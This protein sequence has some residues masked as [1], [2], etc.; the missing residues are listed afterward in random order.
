[1]KIRKKLLASILLVAIVPLII[2]TLSY[3]LFLKRIIINQVV[4]HLE[5]VATIQ[6]QRVNDIIDRNLERMDL[7]SS[8]TQLR[9]S[10]G[11]YLRK[12]NSED[13][14]KMNK[15]LHDARASISDFRHISVISAEGEV[16]ASTDGK[17]IGKNYA[18][19]KYF[20][21]GLKR[22]TFDNF[23]LDINGN[24]RVR[25]SGPIFLDHDFLGVVVIDSKMD[26]IN[27]LT[28]DYT[29]LGESGE[30]I[31]ARR[32]GNGNALILHPLRFDS[33]ATLT[34]TIPT[35]ADKRPIT[36]ALRKKERSMIDAVGYRGVPVIT[37]TRYIERAD[38]GLAVEIDRDEAL[39]PVSRLLL[40]V[41]INIVVYLIIVIV[42]A[43]F[44]SKALIKPI[45]RLTQA[46]KKISENG[47][48][49]ESVEIKNKD[50][51]GILYRAFNEMTQKLFQSQEN[52][53]LQI[54]RMP[55]G[56]LMYDGDLQIHTWNPA[57]EKIF[58]FTAEEAMRKN[59][60]ELIVPKEARN[61][62]DS[63]THRLFE[64]DMDAH[65][66][67]E[68]L[69][70]DGRKILCD[71]TNTPL[72]DS[73]GKVVGILAMVRDI[74][75]KNTLEK[76][77]QQAQKLEAVGRLT[78]GIAHDFN[79]VLSAIIGY[80]D[81]I[82]MKTDKED[83]NRQHLQEIKKAGERA[84]A[85]T[86]QLLA[87]S[88]KQVLKPEVLDPNNVIKELEKMIRRIIGEDIIFMANLKPDVDRI[89]ADPAQMEQIIMNLAINA[90]D[91]MPTGG[92]LTIETAN[93]FLDEGYA[94]HHIAVKPGTYVMLAVS[95]NGVGMDKEIQEHIFEPFYST[96]GE[97]GTGLGLATV[98]GIV[99]QSGGS[100]WVYSEPGQGTTFKIYFPRVE[101]GVVSKKKA[102]KVMES[103]RGTETVLVVEDEYTVRS[104]ISLVLKDN[105]YT[106]LEASNGTEA[107]SIFHQH[108]DQINLL[109]TDAIMPG[110]NG[111]ELAE[112]ITATNPT[113]KV[114][115]ASGYTDDIIVHHGILEEGINFLQKPFAPSLLL[116]TVRMVL[117]KVD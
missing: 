63:I 14:Q 22:K 45:I 29:G 47:Q 95:D 64:G 65:S 97:K 60:Y 6:E 62:V 82:L 18:G 104:M 50:E 99:K 48:L 58:G 107:L 77:L 109:L 11:E 8:K 116:S 25:L 98:Y 5:S 34:K 36:T 13:Q 84:A 19:E 92:K 2:I 103:V 102:K 10:M 91:A 83:E 79:N 110:M 44:Q 101:E 16:V 85:L 71:W 69:T 35:D 52:L 53:R 72:K 20:I 59:P 1:M 51:M 88:R 113:I 9:I 106:I 115:Y 61:H 90:R 12:P 55:I 100:I 93:V 32:D 108:K 105:G 28:R 80:T 15:I 117:D 26:G 67:N 42:L 81:F 7:V 54:D 4:D 73:S 70:K 94:N 43:L 33:S 96:K 24:L 74:T 27:Q 89:K 68:N 114:L 76:Q 39:R 75:E 21:D 3:Y 57:A 111:R 66:V 40:I 37:V 78:G 112:Q 23:F 56:L 49:H 86:H 31:I 41:V 46:A 17:T 38:W 87:F 30:T